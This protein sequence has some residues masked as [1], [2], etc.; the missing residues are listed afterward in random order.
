MAKK[1]LEIIYFY[2]SKYGQETLQSEIPEIVESNKKIYETA[3]QEISKLKKFIQRIE[4]TPELL[5]DK[6]FVLRETVKEKYVEAKEIVNKAE[7]I[8]AGK[9]RRKWKS[10]KNKNE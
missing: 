6:D 10:S 4:K 1:L 7:N 8:M 5:E 9:S 3:M 2:N